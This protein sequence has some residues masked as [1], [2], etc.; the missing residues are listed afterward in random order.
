[1]LNYSL[2]HPP[3]LAAL[4][5]AGHGGRVVLADGNFPLTTAANP[6]AEVVHLNLRPGMVAVTDVLQPLLEAVVVELATVMASPDGS[7]VEAHADYAQLL[8]ADV[9]LESLSRWDFYEATRREDVAVVVATADQRLCANL[10]LTVG[11]RER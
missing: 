6:I 10:V 5:R 4:S 8:G 1:M 3:L 7:P 9:P 11:V 2:L